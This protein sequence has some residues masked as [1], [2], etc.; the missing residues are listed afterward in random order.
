MLPPASVEGLKRLAMSRAFDRR[1]CL[2]TLAGLTAVVVVCT[3]AADPLAGRFLAPREVAGDVPSLNET[4]ESVGSAADARAVESLV[5]EGANGTAAVKDTSHTQ[6]DAAE[7]IPFEAGLD[8]TAVKESKASENLTLIEAANLSAT[9]QK[10]F[11]ER[12][13]FSGKYCD[14]SWTVVT[15]GWR[16]EE[17]RQRCP[18][19]EPCRQSGSRTSATASCGVGD[20]FCKEKFFSGSYCDGKTVV[21]CGFSG[22]VR[23]YQCGYWQRCQESGFR[24]SRS[25]RCQ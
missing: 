22:M 19:T 1:N 21:V 9:W 12:K 25:A 16:G 15:C 24:T 11:C 6:Q 18:Y 14:G 13:F 10:G 5:F 8:D 7:Y 2:S 4:D 3:V 20:G 23:K 17:R